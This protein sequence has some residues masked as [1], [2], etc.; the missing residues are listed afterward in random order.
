MR[1][2]KPDLALA[3]LVLVVTA[4]IVQALMGHQASRL[5]LTAAIVDHRTVVI[6]DY[7]EILS[8]D[9][10]QRDGH[11]YS[12]KA[13]GQPLLAVP[14]YAA[15]RAVG[16]EPAEVY[17]PFDNLTLWWVTLWSAAIP[18][19][20]LAVVIRRF[21]LRV[22]DDPRAA[23]AAGVAV[24]LGTLLAAF[25]T[26]LFSHV[27]AALLGF[28]AW[29]LARPRHASRAQLGWAGL[30]GGLAVV[31][32]YTTGIIVVVTGITVLARHR[33]DVWAFVVGGLPAVALLLGYNALAWGDPFTF[34]YDYSATFGAFH[35]LGFFGIRLP[36]PSLAG[37]VLVG[38]RGLF[39]LTP[40]VAVG[41]IGLV[42]LAL[43]QTRRSIGI[44]G[45]VVFTTFVMVQSGW[46]SA[47]AGASPG[48]RYVVAALPFV[49]I[50]VARMFQRIPWLVVATTAI[51][52]VAM[53]AAI[54]TNPLA[55]PTESFVFGHWVWLLRTGRWDD[56]LVTPWLG[57]PMAQLVQVAVALAMLGWVWQVSAGSSRTR[58]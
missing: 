2:R 33:R 17:R 4:P 44:T 35:E 40:V 54:L 47:T 48:P 16:A 42:D 32:E 57:S 15:A 24:P 14:L 39:T 36:D 25:G 56:T 41:I 19:A 58:R 50:G 53:L 29:V 43:D 9:Y 1:N 37:E 12:D 23:M 38:S 28:A 18:L 45:L 52:A 22:L 46:F 6:D 8:V 11:L 51:G 31:T 34:S 30:L 10:A 49:A 7:D 3:A 26:V 20:V 13:P 21:A 5:A 55:Q 27:L